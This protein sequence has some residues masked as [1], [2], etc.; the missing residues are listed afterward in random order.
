M[1]LRNESRRFDIS[2]NLAA[3]TDARKTTKTF[4]YDA[5]NQLVTQRETVGPSQTITTEFGYDLNGR[6]TRFTDGR[7]SKFATTYN[8]WGLPESQI[9]PATTA[10]PTAADRTF[11]MTYDKGGRLVR[12]DSPGGV[13]VESEYD[14][15]GRL[16]KSSGTGAQVATADKTFTYDKVGRMESFTGSAGTNQIGYDD[17]GLVTSITGVS[18]TSS[19]TYNGNGA[20]TSRTDAAG[21]TSYSYDT[22]GR[23]L[24]V[25]N[26]AAGVNMTYSYDSMSRVEKINYPGTVRTFGY[27]DLQ[28]LTSDTL[29]NAAGT[30]IAKI[31]YEWNLN[32]SL[33]KKTT[34]G[35]NGSSTNTYEYDLANR[36]TLWDNGS[37]PV[38]YDKSGNRIQAGTTTFTYD[39][40]NQL[41]SDSTGATYQ[42]T[43]RGTL[44]STIS[45]GQA[46]VTQ[47]DAF[48]QVKVQ[49]AKTGGSTSY[50]YDGLGRLLQAGMS[51][52]GLGNDVAADGS[53]V[54][55]RDVAD[56]LVAVASG[57]TKRY[58]W[59]DA[60]TD[61]VGEFT[62]TGT[63]L[64]GS[65]S[66]DPWGKVLAAAGMVGKLGFQQEWTDQTTGK[67]NM[68]SRWYDPQTGAFDTRDT[69]DNNPIPT[70]GSANRFAYAEG[71]P[72][73]NTDTTGNAVDGKCGEYDYACALRIYQAA[74]DVYN[75]AMEQRDRDMQAAGAQIAQQEAEFQR[76]EREGRVSLLDIL[77][78]V[79]V[80]MLLDLI[81][82]TSLQGCLGGSLWDCADLASNALG[83]IK[84]LKVGRSLF[85]AAERAFEGYRLWKRIV[86]GARTVMRRASDAINAGRK[87]LN[88]VMK[89]V[90]KKPKLPKK[91][92]KP[93][94][95]KK[96]KPQ[97]RPKPKPQPS[98]QA[99]PEKPK[100]TPKKE[101]APAK[102]A[103]PKKPEPTNKE[104]KKRA[105]QQGADSSESERRD[106]ADLTCTR[107]HSFDPDT[108]VL[109]AD[110]STRRIAEVAVGDEVRAT[111]PQTGKDGARQVTVL[112][113]N[114]DLELTDVTVSD[115]PT[116]TT[117]A[118]GR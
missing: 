61:V 111:D 98:Q 50:R 53:T 11:T 28:Q 69:A 42:Y 23:P 32:D 97:P 20:L 68:W 56:N 26:A 33:T 63:T 4:A 21:T 108:L 16:R 38:A 48:N 29:K 78:Q 43:P 70:S 76:A 77:L 25:E 85:R 72:L 89:K 80:G 99:K 74:M 83:P 81:G 92:K 64:T 12:V 1:L 57:S 107:T 116:D 45:G 34:T 47:T 31:D 8:S 9:E 27:N 54:Y 86:E 6:Q 37:T 2:G 51:Y 95:K 82:Y 49:G 103:K 18:G 90:P 59:T 113:A 117:R 17:R 96:P 35:F 46:V 10:T 79:G 60:H 87:L 101:N 36:L 93:A 73:S 75:D 94:A 84:A 44:Q 91:K 114:R 52:T 105:E 67:V 71:D 104:P 65:V 110:G 100:T 55:V 115:Q 22:A 13:K 66:Y 41:V 118:A 40:R 102:E 39:Q 106:P 62:D 5:L 3:A 88:D 14:A 112:H 24:K 19:Y 109:M 15:M 58:A 30:T 7:G